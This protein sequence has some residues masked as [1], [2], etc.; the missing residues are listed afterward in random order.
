MAFSLFGKRDKTPEA[1]EVP[2]STAQDET[3]SERRGFFDRMKQAVTRTR[4]TLS[5]SIAGVIALT[6][7]IDE[8]SLDE[9]EFALLASDIGSVTTDEIIT[10]LRDR[11]LR[12]GISDGAELKRL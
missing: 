1:P 4:E 8:S 7:E 3:G 12:Q 2:A 5:S 6:R 10:H 9:L 11:A